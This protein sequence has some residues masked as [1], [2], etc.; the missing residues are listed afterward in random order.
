MEADKPD[1]QEG[2]QLS[3]KQLASRLDRLE[4][5]HASMIEMYEKRISKLENEVASLKI[6]KQAIADILIKSF[7]LPTKESAESPTPIQLPPELCT[8]KAMLLWK[9]AIEAGY[10][11]VNY[12]P[13][14]SWT[15]TALLA[16]VMAGELGIRC[17]WKVFGTFWNLNNLGTDYYRALNQ[18]NGGDNLREIV[19]LLTNS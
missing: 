2:C 9:K 18:I 13:L 4:K 11:D 14:L 6:Q 8:E 1:N 7:D 3:Y 16:H 19:T 17:K 12:Q 10:V 15:K 5:R